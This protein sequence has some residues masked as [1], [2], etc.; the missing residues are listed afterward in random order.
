MNV[1]KLWHFLSLYSEC[2]RITKIK[3]LENQLIKKCVVSSAC[4]CV[5]RGCVCADVAKSE[6][7]LKYHLVLDAN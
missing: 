6:P 5:C 7:L 1:L 3:C 2:F 4:M